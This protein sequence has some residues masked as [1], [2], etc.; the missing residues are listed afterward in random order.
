MQSK[1]KASIIGQGYVGLPLA[2][3]ASEA[4][5]EVNGIDIDSKKI[6]LINSGKSPVE[7]I[8]DARLQKALASS[9]YKA[10]TD[11]SKISDSNVIIICVPTP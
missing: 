5:L 7:D 3:A 11:F 1:P 8:S 6:D 9:A 10:T 2:I 4:G